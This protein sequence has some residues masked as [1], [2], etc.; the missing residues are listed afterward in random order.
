MRHFVAVFSVFLLQASAAASAQV[1]EG[2]WFRIS[3][4]D[5][6][7]ASGSLPS[8]T[9]DGFDSA[10]FRDPVG[11]IEFYVYSPQAGGTATD[12]APD[13]ARETLVATEGSRSADRTFRWT[14]Y[15]T[16]DGTHFRSIEE[17]RT[18]DR[19]QVRVFA[20]RYRSTDDLA[21]FRKDYMDFKQSFQA[22]AD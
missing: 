17:M 16:N 11:R 4:P 21:A 22:F 1:F 5:G 6:F 18:T 15:A 8:T 14:T 20:I 10:F 19:L 9:N 2:A 7:V 13:A 3:Y 12:I